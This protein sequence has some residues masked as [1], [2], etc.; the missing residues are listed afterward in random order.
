MY[1]RLKVVRLF[2]FAG[3]WDSWRAGAEEIL[4]CTIITTSAN[5]LV[6]PIHDRM[7]VILAPEGYSEWLD[8][9]E[10]TPV[11]LQ[12]L[13]NPILL[14]LWKRMRFLPM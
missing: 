14:T 4:S 10:R 12:G 11:S 5:E 2:A 13:L 8:M 1:V 6:A 3:L 9:K 7:P